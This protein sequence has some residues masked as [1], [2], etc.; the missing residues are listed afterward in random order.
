MVFAVPLIANALLRQP[1]F[2]PGGLMAAVWSAALLGQEVFA[3]DFVFSTVASWTILVVIACF[4]IGDY[5]I[6]AITPAHSMQH[7]HRP[8]NENL[9]RTITIGCGVV[10]V[11]GSAWSLVSYV[12]YFGGITEFATAGNAIRVVFA[13][14][15]VQLP[16]IARSMAT[17]GHPGVVLSLVGWSYFGW[18]W[19]M[20]LPFFAVAM[21]AT[22]QMGRAGVIIVA[23]EGLLA[24]YY[25]DIAQGKGADSRFVLRIL[26]AAG[27]VLL[28]FIGGE[29]FRASAAVDLPIA[30]TFYAYAFSGPSGLTAWL[31]SAQVGVQPAL[32]RQS[33]DS[34]AAL[35]GAKTQLVGVYDDFAQLSV[36]HADIGNIYT[37][38]RP[39]VEDF[40]TVGAAAM[41]LVL[42]LI[43]GV[44]FEYT[45]CRS[46]P[47]RAV[48][49]TLGVYIVFSVITP[50][51]VFNS[52]LLS[53][54]LPPAVLLWATVIAERPPSV[55]GRV[56]SDAAAL[57]KQ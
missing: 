4:V 6:V 27:S 23:L 25:R 29:I 54:A 50:L 37:V 35:L 44:A 26:P 3:P 45:R 57:P 49:I 10:S 8:T 21:F 19:W 13:E 38:I 17:F 43:A 15:E 32:G 20:S 1:V 9:I 14:R 31:D 28:L 42:G 22:S 7:V 40:G 51:S 11:I 46:L 39:L 18:R 5:I 53:V 52:W 47:A 36:R 24:I 16:F 12:H 30:R 2:R 48:A 41:M 55:Q 34:L 33:F 56:S